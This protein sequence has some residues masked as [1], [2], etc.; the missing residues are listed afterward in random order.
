MT[1]S[2]EAVFRELGLNRILAHQVIFRSRHPNRTP[3]FH[4]QLIAD[5]HSP[6]QYVMEIV[7]RGGGK[8]TIAEEG[9]CLNAGFREFRNGIIVG[10]IFDRAAERLLSIK[11]EIETNEMLD[12]V[13]GNLKGPTWSDDE[14]VLSNGIRILAMG[15]GQ[16][17]R[18]IKFRDQR[19]DFFYWDDIE[20]EESVRTPESRKK[21]R[22][23]AIKEFIPACDVS[24]HKG[25]VSATPLDPDD[26]THTLDKGDD[27]VS[28]FLVRR[29]P[30]EH[31]GANGVRTATWPDRI[32]VKEIDKIKGRFA[33]AGMMREYNMEY[34]CLSEAAEDKTFRAE[35]F[36]TEATVRTWQNVYT[37][38]DPARTVNSQSAMTGYAAWS[39]IGN[40]LVVW[41]AWGKKLLPDEQI[42]AIFQAEEDF[43]PAHI[44]VEEDG[45]NEW[46]LQPLRQEQVKRGVMLPLRPM[47]APKGKNDFIRGLQPFFGAREIVFAKELPELRQQLLS[48]PRGLI[49]VPNALAYAL[50]MRP[51]A[52]MYDDFSSRHVAE[53][54]KPLSSKTSWLAMNATR[55]FVSAVLL[56]A[57]DGCLRIYA[58]WTREGEPG[59]VIWDIIGE[60]NAEAGRQVSVTVGPRHYDQFNNFGL[61][62]ALRAIPLDVRRGVGPEL[63]RR[64]VR[65]NLV[66]ELRGLPALMVDSRAR[67]TLNG[68]AGGYARVLLKQGMLADHAEEGAYRILM[69]GIESFV[70][71]LNVGQVEDD[72]DDDA[73]YA[74]NA[75]GLRYRTALGNR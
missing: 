74:V 32:P 16:S 26:L 39:W 31:V 55:S 23:W 54:M 53:D 24:N 45:L 33:K 25:R 72:E 52:P 20:S 10:E 67:W 30:I 18:G 70:G 12:Q 9:F 64:F 40:R 37:M 5:W 21:A 44:G 43:H 75:R 6:E 1:D 19:P 15:R 47:K 2:H 36:R 34:M 58:D 7:F 17:I 73:H 59:A 27:G 62:Q 41:D 71:L 61:V 8:S 66:R 60:A 4:R 35:M 28:G 63:G 38:F 50:I 68:F 22:T 57:I 49:D 13:F 14:I 3:D 11:H 46:L 42:K 56:Q 51:G 48:F 29:F 65:D 69:E